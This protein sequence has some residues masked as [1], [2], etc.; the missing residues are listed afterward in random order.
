MISGRLSNPASHYWYHV[1]WLGKDLPATAKFADLT[2]HYPLP[3]GEG[4]P[5]AEAEAADGRQAEHR[6]MLIELR[7]TGCQTL[8]PPSIHPS[9]E[10]V[11]WERVT[12]GRRDP[13]RIRK[14]QGKV[15]APELT[16]AVAKVAAVA[17]LARH[18]PA[19]GERDEAAKDLAGLLLRGGW[20][21]EEVDEFTRLA[22]KI[23]DDEEWQQRGKARGTARKLAE[24]AHV[25]GGRSLAARLSGN[26]ADG[27]RIVARLVVWL[28]LRE[29]DGGRGASG[30]LGGLGS[31]YVAEGGQFAEGGQLSDVAPFAG[32][33]QLGEIGQLLGAV[34]PTPA[35]PLWGGRLYLG[36]L[37]ICDGDPGHGKTLLALDLAA[38]ITTGREMPDGSAAIGPAGVVYFTAEDDP[39]D[40]LRPRLDAA[41][42][43]PNRLL[44]VT[45]V[46]I[47]GLDGVSSEHQPTFRDLALIERAIARVEAKLVIFDPFMAYLDSQTN[48]FRDQ[49]VRAVLA[50]LARLAERTGAAFFLIRHLN[51]GGG[52]HAVYRGGGSIGII[53]AARSGLLVGRDPDDA[54][55]RVVASTKNNLGM[56]PAS[57]AYRV[58][59][60]A[61]GAPI[62]QWEGESPHDARAL[63]VGEE[64]SPSE[65][66]VGR[67]CAFLSE[68]LAQGPQPERVIEEHARAT[69]ISERTLK[70]AKKRLGIVSGKAGFSNGWI[71]VA[72]Q[73]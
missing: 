49:D 5:E 45:T 25:T 4:E 14:L 24:G 11:R 48:S 69:G 17:L 16:R 8:A 34:T 41:G 64:A 7:S 6:S 67:A 32:G 22:A 27:V 59:P 2:P 3:R 68:A 10:F 73:R 72:L 36:K 28:G 19:V 60:S 30:E 13:D 42:G 61:S 40:T 51:K 63:L 35:R 21:E 38:R 1:E 57:L 55:R 29:H 44:V 71:S 33:G 46:A 31:A 66:G 62:I 65:M 54:E 15:T 18:W 52:G 26:G 9:G 43:D 20:A 70:R 58:I 53:G 39:A 12:T 50:P 23:A 47:T 56:P 37:A